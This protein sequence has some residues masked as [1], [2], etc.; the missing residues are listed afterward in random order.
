MK[1]FRFDPSQM[2]AEGGFCKV[3][4]GT[5][6]PKEECLEAVIKAFKFKGLDPED[7]EILR[8]IY[9]NEIFV[10]EHL[11]HPDFPRLY[12]YTEIKNGNVPD[13]AYI[14]MEFFDV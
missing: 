4:K 2:L 11:D 5:Y 10:L 7:A 8:R 14:A 1:E 6:D 9:E 3:F 12:G 13:E